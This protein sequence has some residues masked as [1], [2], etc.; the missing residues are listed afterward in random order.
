MS[1]LT[2]DAVAEAVAFGTGVLPRLT[3][4]ELAQ[5]L[6]VSLRHLLRCVQ[7][8]RKHFVFDSE[9]S[10][11]AIRSSHEDSILVNS[12]TAWKWFIENVCG[13]N[14]KIAMP[15]NNQTEL[16]RN[17]N[18]PIRWEQQFAYVFAPHIT[19]QAAGEGLNAKMTAIEPGLSG[20]MVR[21]GLINGTGNSPDKFFFGIIATES[22]IKSRRSGR[23]QL[24]LADATVE[25]MEVDSWVVVEP[26]KEWVKSE[27]RYVVE[28]HIPVTAGQA[29]GVTGATGHGAD[30]AKSPN[31]PSPVPA[32]PPVAPVVPVVSAPTPPPVAVAVPPVTPGPQGGLNTLDQLSALLQPA[33]AADVRAI[34]QDI[35]KNAAAPEPTVAPP[36]APP[37]VAV[38]PRSAVPV[39]PASPAAE[40]KSAVEAN[41]MLNDLL[42]R[43]GG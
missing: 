35:R 18:R 27:T 28:A 4:I 34:K 7:S 1:K 41:A 22:E 12:N 25:M 14:E 6:G 39:V 40:P 9:K 26:E 5:V 30:Y 29:G 36:P 21:L 2:R 37:A 17:T 43:I 20:R 24:F 13:G 38:A 32:H 16:A 10:V 15:L 31:P 8:N 11:T 42:G 19:D 33:P 3:L 23:L